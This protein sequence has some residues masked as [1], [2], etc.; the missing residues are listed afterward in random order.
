MSFG[1]EI[2]NQNSQ[3]TIQQTGANLFSQGKY[4]VKDKV[5]RSSLQKTIVDSNFSTQGA[6]GTIRFTANGNRRNPF[7]ELETVAQCDSFGNKLAFIPLN[8][9]GCF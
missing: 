3:L 8:Y 1:G 5:T 2:I 9:E 6:I 7:V 4:K